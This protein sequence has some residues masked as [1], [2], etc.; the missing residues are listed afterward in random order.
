MQNFHADIDTRITF[1][2]LNEDGCQIECTVHTK[3][4]HLFFDTKGNLY[5]PDLLPTIYLVDNRTDCHSLIGESGNIT[6]KY[7]GAIR[8]PGV[9]VADM[10]AVLRY[11]EL[12]GRCLAILR[13]GQTLVDSVLI[14]SSSS[15]TSTTTTSRPS[16]ATTEQPIDG[17][18]LYTSKFLKD[19]NFQISPSPPF[20]PS[21]SHHPPCQVKILQVV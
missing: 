18:V 7:V 6:V 4:G 14:A 19:Y 13:R 3:K 1:N 5:D 15:T 11:S 12:N 8:G 2:Q 9:V 17:R 21:L 20:P 16:P 10:S